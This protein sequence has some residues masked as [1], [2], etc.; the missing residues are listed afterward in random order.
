LHGLTVYIFIHTW[1]SE[2][3]AKAAKF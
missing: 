3:L 2:K 1:I